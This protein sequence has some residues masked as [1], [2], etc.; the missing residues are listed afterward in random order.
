MYR[1]FNIT[2]SEKKEILKHHIS[3]GYRKPLNNEFS[4]GSKLNEDHLIKIIEKTIQE[5]INASTNFKQGQLSGF[6]SGQ[7]ARQVVDNVTSEISKAGKE[8]IITIGKVSFT[9]LTYG[10]ATVWLIGKGIYKVNTAITNTLIKFIVSTTKA[11]VSASTALKQSTINMLKSLN[12]AIEKGA[13][14]VGQQINNLKDVSTQIVKW[15]INQFKQFGVKVWAGVLL[16]AAKV[17][18]WSGT[19]MGW[20]KQ[21]YSTIA[22]QVGVAF[23]N[24]ISDVKNIASNV[25]SGIKSAAQNIGANVVNSVSNKAGQLYGGIQGFLQEFF[26]RFNSFKSNDT[27]QILSESMKFNGLITL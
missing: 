7:Q 16:S 4:Y 11:V 1:N 10:A 2:E 24:A 6:S 17:K 21:S 18:E 3:H 20:I 8:T 25:G 13:Q 12:I 26:E 27:L 19:L 5:Q 23:D 22:S 15:V 14:F 9:V